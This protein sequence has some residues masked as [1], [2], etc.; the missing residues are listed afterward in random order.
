VRPKSRATLKQ[1]RNS[2]GIFPLTE[3]EPDERGHPRVV[4]RR[5]MRDTT[6]RRVSGGGLE[7]VYELDDH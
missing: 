4:V 7:A 5:S 3:L 6:W 2:G 1:L